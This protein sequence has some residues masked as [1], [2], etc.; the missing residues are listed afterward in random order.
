MAAAVDGGKAP[1]MVTFREAARRAVAEGVAVTMT[2]QR[3]SQL[4]G[5]DKGFPPTQKV[6]T[7]RTVSWKALRAYLKSQ[8][9]AAAVRD[10]R[11]RKP[12]ADAAQ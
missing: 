6:G 10:S 1:D 3:L 8:Q 11:R 2:H 7:G 12:D 4:A 9:A 5:Q